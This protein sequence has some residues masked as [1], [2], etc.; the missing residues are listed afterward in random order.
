LEDR[1]AKFLGSA[2]GIR[3]VIFDYGDVLC[4]RA[5]RE[6]FAPMAAILGIT[7]ERL[8]ERYM[9][10]RLAY[11]RGDVSMEDYWIGF[12][13]EE[14]TEITRAQAAELDRR[15]CE[16]WWSLDPALM[17]WIEHLRGRGIKT[18]ILSNMFVNMARKLR[19]EAPW[20]DRFDAYTLSG[21]LRLAKPEPAIYQHA[22]EQLGVAAA[23]ALFLDDRQ[24]NVDGA[25]AVGME[26]LVFS[27]A[28]QLRKDLEAWGFHVLPPAE[29]DCGALK[30]F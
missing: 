30:K 14:G 6:K 1:K 27:S 2:S 8:V 21:E 23:E 28:A 18:G 3:A 17:E 7:P 26:G 16:L 4:L 25:R 15:D 5:P 24:V 12:G 19:E 10:N 13:R 20:A 29:R 11:D 9:Q 22:A